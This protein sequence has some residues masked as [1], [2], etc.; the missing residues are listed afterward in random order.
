MAGH[1][2]TIADHGG[3]KP[4]RYRELNDSMT[5]LE[6]A[7]VYLNRLP[8]QLDNYL[9]ASNRKALHQVIQAFEQFFNVIT[10]IDTKAG[11]NQLITEA[12]A[13]DIGDHGLLLLIKIVDLMEH[14]ELLQKRKEVE[15]ISLIFARWIFSYGGKINHLE[16]LVNAFA[17]LANTMRDHES[18]KNLSSL[19]GQV[20]DAC[21]EEIKLDVDKN[22]EFRPWRL[23][24]INRGIVATRTHDLEIM[25]NA[26]DEL[27]IYL[28]QEANSFFDEGMREMDALNY[29]LHV[30]ELIALY[31]LKKSAINLH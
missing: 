16:P 31:Q 19:M 30:R 15:Q 29:P 11:E 21:S 23:L 26:F 18:L 1:S 7:R 27:L 3:S 17:H 2:G 10:R 5:S 4:F 6:D 25:K 28:P 22:D 24:H 12:E 13:T 20:V 14:V 9:D 8:S